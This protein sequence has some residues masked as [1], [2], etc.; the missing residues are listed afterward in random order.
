[1]YRLSGTRRLSLAPQCG[2]RYQP[3]VN[4]HHVGRMREY[5]NDPSA[6]NLLPKHRKLIQNGDWNELNK[7]RT[8]QVS[9]EDRLISPYYS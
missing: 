7:E 4:T 9:L 1:M 2:R 6:R 5:N 3:T 8:R